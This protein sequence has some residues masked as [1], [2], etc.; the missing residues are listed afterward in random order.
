MTRIF[1]FFAASTT[2]MT[3]ILAIATITLILSSTI[4]MVATDIKQVW[5]YSTVSQLGYMAMGL[6]AAALASGNLFAGYY[7]LTTH[8]LKALFFCSGVFIHHFALMISLP[9][10]PRGRG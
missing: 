3:V 6:A 4:G 8:A 5:A 7:H 2:T 10:P 9:W 1:P